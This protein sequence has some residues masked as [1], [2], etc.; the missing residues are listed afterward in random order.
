MY[1]MKRFC[2]N[3]IFIL[4]FGIFAQNLF[5]TELFN[6]KL[7]AEEKAVLDKGEVLI[8]NI[9]YPKN[10]SISKGYNSTIDTVIDEIKSLSPKYLA[11]IIQIKPYEG[12]ENLPEAASTARAGCRIHI[13][14][15]ARSSLRR[16]SRRQRYYPFPRRVRDASPDKKWPRKHPPRPCPRPV[17]SFWPHR[18]DAP[19]QSASRRP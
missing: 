19:G 7:T 17:S 8:K 15:K 14:R 2:R 5:C 4:C 1:K 16:S 6:N 12:N 18:S 11:E 3:M 9:A 13:P 10:M